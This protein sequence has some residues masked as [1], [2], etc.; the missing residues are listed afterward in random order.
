MK[1]GELRWTSWLFHDLNTAW[2]LTTP[3]NRVY[4]NKFRRTIAFDFRNWLF[5]RSC[6]LDSPKTTRLMNSNF[7]VSFSKLRLDFSEISPQTQ[8]RCRK[9]LISDRESE[10]YIFITT[11]CGNVRWTDWK[12]SMRKICF[13]S[14]AW[15][16]WIWYFRYI[17]VDLGFAHFI[18]LETKL[19][20]DNRTDNAKLLLYGVN[21]LGW[22]DKISSCL[23]ISVTLLAISK[24]KQVINFAVCSKNFSQSIFSC[25]FGEIIGHT[26]VKLKVRDFEADEKSQ[27]VCFDEHY[28]DFV[29]VNSFQL[30]DITEESSIMTYIWIQASWRKTV[31]ISVAWFI[32]FQLFVNCVLCQVH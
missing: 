11:G 2:A 3:K 12:L 15:R 9:H 25:C 18:R 21:F 19:S 30:Q 17:K 1:S 26:G 27:Q 4:T 31:K 20:W 14:E 8:A 16:L 23:E 28:H 32:V 10:Q 5:S 22:N 29:D 24:R 13:L 7:L 6:E